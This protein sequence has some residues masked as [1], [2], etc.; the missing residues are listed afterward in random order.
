MRI[1]KTKEILSGSYYI[2]LTRWDNSL[3]RLG[4]L[5]KYMR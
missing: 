1:P 2:G 4:Q 5:K 3:P